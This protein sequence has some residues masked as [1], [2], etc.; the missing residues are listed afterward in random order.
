MT[1][2]SNVSVRAVRVGH[3]RPPS[4]RLDDRLHGGAETDRRR[5][6]RHRLD[7]ARGAARHGAPGGRAEDGE[8]AVVVEELEQV[9][10]RVV[11]R[12]RRDRRT[13]P[14]PRAGRGSARVKYG[15]E[16]AAARRTRPAV[17]SRSASVGLAGQ[18]GAGLAVEPFT[19]VSIR[20]YAGPGEVAAAGNRPA[21]RLRAGIL[22][23][24]LVVDGRTCSCPTPASRRRARRT[25]A[26]GW[27]RCGRCAR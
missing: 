5:A 4:V 11:Q 19:S 8:H 17:S 2:A 26:A 9:A 12:R 3:A 20:R 18:H 22:E 14:P 27:G 10:G 6:G 15:A 23:A 1:T 21:G 7:V 16:A 25:G 13:T 24:R